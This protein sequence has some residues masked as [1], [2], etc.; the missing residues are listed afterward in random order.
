MQ[1]AKSLHGAVLLISMGIA[2]CAGGAEDGVGGAGGSGATTSSSTTTTAVSGSTSGSTGSGSEGCT[3]LTTSMPPKVSDVN[4]PHLAWYTP[5]ADNPSLSDVLDILFYGEPYVPAVGTYDL[6]SS[7]VNDNF[8]TCAQCVNYYERVDVS[9]S[10]FAHAYF[11][12]S[13]T[14]T[15]TET[16]PTSPN[17]SKGSLTNVKLIEVTIDF[18]TSKSTPVP[19]G[20]CF[21]VPSVTWDTMP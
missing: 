4:G 9:S 19:G 10:S 16:D 6:G 21:F 7:G 14:M 20:A 2:G 15:I 8:Q 1:M 12:E 3:M 13:G 5:S 17:H 18:G 11:Q